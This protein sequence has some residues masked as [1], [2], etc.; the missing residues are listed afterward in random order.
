MNQCG[1]QIFRSPC[2]GE[3]TGFAGE[4]PLYRPVKSRF[5]LLTE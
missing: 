5:S 2:V 3:S 4:S 1:N